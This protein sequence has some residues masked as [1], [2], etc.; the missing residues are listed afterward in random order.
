MGITLV[1]LD[2]R[3]IIDMYWDVIFSKND[4][5]DRIFPTVSILT[6]LRSEWCKSIRPLLDHEMCSQF[7]SIKGSFTTP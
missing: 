1:V 2:V 4:T 5:Y 3:L 7:Y 6:V